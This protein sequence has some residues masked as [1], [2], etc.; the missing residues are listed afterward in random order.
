M[1][2]ARGIYKSAKVGLC[3]I[4]ILYFSRHV[5]IIIQITRAD[6]GL[7]NANRLPSAFTTLLTKAD[8][9]SQ[10]FPFW[11][12]LINS[13]VPLTLLMGECHQLLPIQSASLKNNILPLCPKKSLFLGMPSLWREEKSIGWRLEYW[14][15][16]ECWLLVH[17]MPRNLFLELSGVLNW[18][19]FFAWPPLLV[20]WMAWMSRSGTLPLTNTFPSNSILKL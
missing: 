10:T 12:C 11:I 2:Q 19:P 5:S 18:I 9:L 8:L 6:I 17:T 4:S 15:L 1:Y 3:Q 13:R 16:T 14:K 20:Y 7:L